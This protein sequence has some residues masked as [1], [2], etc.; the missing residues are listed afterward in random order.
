MKITDLKKIKSLFFFTKDTLRLLEKN[1]FNLDANLKYW[2]KKEKV[3]R[4]KKGFYLIKS[5]FEKYGDKEGYLEYLA[6]RIYEP[7]YLTGEY[8]MSKYGL[9]TEAVYSITS[10]TTNKTKIFENK[11]GKFM[12]YSIKPKLF[13]GYTIKKFFDTNIFI[14]KKTKAVFDFLYLRFLKKT[15]INEKSVQELRINWENLSKKEFKEIKKF[16][17]LADSPRIK[18][19]INLIEKKI[20]A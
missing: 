15:P 5:Q 17:L 2:V 12:Y 18:K 20:Y 4:L 14:A 7:S 3:I 10:I 11:L 6:N 1:T 9:L 13:I 16:G 19:V 8:V